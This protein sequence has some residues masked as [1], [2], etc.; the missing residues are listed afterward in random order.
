VVRHPAVRA[1][2]EADDGADLPLGVPVHARLAEASV[3][4][5][6]VLFRLP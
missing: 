2:I 3:P 1:R 6:T 5:R 4:R